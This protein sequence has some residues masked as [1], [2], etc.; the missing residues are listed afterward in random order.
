M[1]Q[2]ADSCL[3]DNT[4]SAYLS[5]SLSDHDYREVVAHLSTCEACLTITS[6]ALA[7]DDE[8]REAARTIGR[9]TLLAMLGHGPTASIY[10]A[11]D[12]VR[13]LDVA[14]KVVP[15]KHSSERLLR[16][17]TTL[18]T[19]HH[20]NLVAVRESGETD[21]G[22]FIAMEV[23]EGEPLSTWLGRRHSWREIVRMFVAA[24]RGMAQAHAAGVQRVGFGTDNVLVDGD[25]V[26]T[27]LRVSVAADTEDLISFAIALHEALYGIAPGTA[28]FI[29]DKD[30]APARVHDAL[31]AAASG[32]RSGSLTELLDRLERR[33]HVRR[34]VAVAAGLVVLAAIVSLARP[35]ERQTT[36]PVALDIPKLVPA[37]VYVPP[38]VNTTGDANLDDTLDVVTAAVLGAPAIAGGEL[39]IS[40]PRS[41]IVVVRGTVRERFVIAL[42]ASVDERIVFRGERGATTRD[43]LVAATT[44]LTLDLMR[45]LGE[46]PPLN[47][48]TLSTS[49][50]AIHVW[51]QAQHDDDPTHAIAGYEEALS[52]DPK[53]VAAQGTLA[54]SLGSAADLEQVLRTPDR[55]PARELVVLKG[56]Y[57]RRLGRYLDALETYQQW[58][59][60]WPEDARTQAMLSE[61]AILAGDFSLALTSAR[62]TGSGGRNLLVAELGN[63]LLADVIRDGE[64]MLAELTRFDGAALAALGSAYALLGHH[65]EAIRTIRRLETA[66]PALAAN[67]AIFD[68]RLDDAVALLRTTSTPSAQLL[69]ANVWLRQG[70]PRLARAAAREAMASTTVRIQYLAASAALDAGDPS[71]ASS[72]L[73]AWQGAPDADRRVY[74][75]M[76][77]GDVARRG[78]HWSAALDEYRAASRLGDA[79]IIHDRLARASLGAGDLEAA[80]REVAWCLDHRGQAAL[81]ANLSLAL[82]PELYLE[83][84]RI[85][86]SMHASSKQTRDAYEAVADLGRSAQ[87][88]PWTDE[89]RLRLKQLPR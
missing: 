25:R 62:A 68:G 86:L 79:W 40:R 47:P 2:Q 53:F 71:A 56:A 18:A 6:A 44:A 1:S 34:S 31:R 17:A 9:Y 27:T 87:H 46:S 28:D 82:L 3:D 10:L 75:H 12:P 26:V 78:A 30:D 15:H 32:Q 29:P 16:D 49:V 54:A 89:A 61:T 83:R 51:L 76:L 45:A 43:G 55:I 37:L 33:T 20:P 66:E 14:L 74:R 73:Q 72:T 59:A 70:R 77:A 23:L 69:L 13:A 8:P 63:E 19:A 38:F 65:D 64:A 58:V 52:L 80:N 35:H 67:L 39:R 85:V 50:A 5:R 7:E 41:S 11:H 4:V 57:F 42:E 81:S 21:D 36:M 84:A 22:D 60:K 24:G 88:D 48:V